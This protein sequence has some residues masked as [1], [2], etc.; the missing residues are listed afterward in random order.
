MLRFVTPGALRDPGL[1]ADIPSGCDQTSNRLRTCQN[2]CVTTRAAPWLLTVAAPRLNHSVC[3]FASSA[4]SSRRRRFRTA[5]LVH[6]VLMPKGRD[7]SHSRRM[8]IV[9]P[10][11]PDH[12]RARC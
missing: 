12:Q 3:G 2:L 11:L 1:I 4:V 10:S 5:P 6:Q 7:W 8:S 9:C